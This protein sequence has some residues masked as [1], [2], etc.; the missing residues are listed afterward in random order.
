MGVLFLAQLRERLISD[1]DVVRFALRKI[2]ILVSS[3]T[4]YSTLSYMERNALIEGR[5]AGRKRIYV[6]TNTSRETNPQHEEKGLISQFEETLSHPI[7]GM[8]PCYCD[9]LRAKRDYPFSLRNPAH[10]FIKK[11]DEVAEKLVN[12]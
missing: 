11:L 4:V 12:Y 5:W 2:H 3:G 10:P 1:H 9:V 7:I 6:L 8:I